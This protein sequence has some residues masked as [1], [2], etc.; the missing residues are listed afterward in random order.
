[1]RTLLVTICLVL[2][3]W[4]PTQFTSARAQL[5]E[6]NASDYPTWS[7]DQSLLAFELYKDGTSNIW[8]FDPVASELENLTAGWEAFRKFSPAWSPNS[9]YI[10][11]ISQDHEIDTTIYV[12]NRDGQVVYQ[13][14]DPGLSRLQPPRWS[15]SGAYL[16]FVAF[17]GPDTNLLKIIDTR[18]RDIVTL[19]GDDIPFIENY[20]WDDDNHLILVFKEIQPALPLP[21]Y[22]HAGL[23]LLDRTTMS[24]R[25][26]IPPDALGPEAFVSEM[27]V[28]D[29]DAIIARVVNL[30]PGVSTT[31]YWINVVEGTASDMTPNAGMVGSFSISPDQTSMVFEVRESEDPLD[32]ESDLWKLDLKTGELSNLTNGINFGNANPSWSPDGKQITFV[33]FLTQEIH[34]GEIAV[35][36]VVESDIW[37]MNADGSDVR[38]LIDSSEFGS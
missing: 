29:S 28:L 32:L 26:L 34:I 21:I 4:S 13:F 6:F 18:S 16:A 22:D 8:V 15:P 9:K 1:M 3:V 12:V 17:T 10:A 27:V 33:G 35:P 23:G 38:M 25:P 37:I 5:P 24:I 20:A 30:G 36:S 31:I 14:S 11:L 7:P 2:V 19:S